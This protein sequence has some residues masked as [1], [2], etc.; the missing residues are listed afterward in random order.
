[1]ATES[2]LRLVGSSTSRNWPISKDAASYAS[3]TSNMAAQDLGLLLQGHGFCGGREFTGP[4]RSGSA[5][6][7]MEGSSLA[8]GD[9]R[10]QNSN[11]EGIFENLTSTVESH[12][13]EEQ[14]RADPTYLAYYHSNVN[15]NPRLPPLLVSRDNKRLVH[16]IGSFGENRRAPSFDDII[17][18]SFMS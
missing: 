2:P 14:L 9:L 7:S 11:L 13:Y 8:I 12:E 5:P 10:S 16:H 18:G 17:K 1:M 6:P 4:N 3:S 15:L